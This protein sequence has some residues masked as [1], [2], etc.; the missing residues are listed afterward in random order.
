MS[1]LLELLARSILRLQPL[2]VASE[3][4]GERAGAQSLLFDL[5]SD[6][7]KIPTVPCGSIFEHRVALRAQTHSISQPLRLEYIPQPTGRY[8]GYQLRKP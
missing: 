7:Q 5:C 2:E 3:R 4:S 8:A 1:A 6:P